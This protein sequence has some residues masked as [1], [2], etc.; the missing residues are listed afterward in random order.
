MKLLRVVIPDNEITPKNIK[1]AKLN[2]DK[3]TTNLGN[4]SEKF[5]PKNIRITN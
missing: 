1:I 5:T 3:S 4:N 2:I